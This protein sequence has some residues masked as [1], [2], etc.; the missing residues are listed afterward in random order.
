L[1]AYANLIILTL[2]ILGDPTATRPTSDEEPAHEV[3]AQPNDQER[4]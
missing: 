4:Q 1:I 2:M 3:A